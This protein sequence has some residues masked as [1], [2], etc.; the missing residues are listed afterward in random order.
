MRTFFKGLTVTTLLLLPL[1]GEANQRAIHLSLNLPAAR[2]DQSTL[3]GG[4]YTLAVQLRVKNAVGFV[5]D[6][7]GGRG[8][9]LVLTDPDNCLDMSH[10]FTAGAFETCPGGANE[11]FVRFRSEASDQPG[12]SD[13]CPAAVSDRLIDDEYDPSNV[14]ELNKPYLFALEGADGGNTGF[15][16]V[17]RTV[18]AF[19]GGTAGSTFEFQDCYGLASDDDLPGLV[20]MADIGPLRVFDENFDL[21]GRRIRNFAGMLNSVSIELV[22]KNDQSYIRAFLRVPNGLLEPLTL[23]DRSLANSTAELLTRRDSGPIQSF[24]FP[25]FPGLVDI[26][27]TYPDVNVTVQAVI[28][29]GQ[30]PNFIDDLDGNNRFTARDLQL[31]GYTLLSNQATIEIH[32]IQ[33]DVLA[34]YSEFVKCPVAIL[35]GDLDG[36]GS[37]G[38]SCNTGNARS[39][40]RP[41]T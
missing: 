30:A 25:S 24:D 35:G 38:Y 29:D 18:G 7:S 23:I 32:A 26:L 5:D 34:E 4:N 13:S 39:I 41:P 36:D 12:Q 28:V 8:E 14:F 31:A 2:G 33:N 1:D 27:S 9:A 10:F 22:D 40:K 15:D 37:S 17:T 19:T 20:L 21:V 11:S 6:G 3:T 16:L